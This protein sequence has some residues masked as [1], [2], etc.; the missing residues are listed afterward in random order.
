M[1]QQ[2]KNILKR[3]PPFKQFYQKIVSVEGALLKE[4][5]CL[6]NENAFIK[7]ALEQQN[8][9]VS[10]L[11]IQIKKLTAQLND[12]IPSQSAYLRDQIDNIEANL[13][14]LNT[15][16]NEELTSKLSG[17]SE[18]LLALEVDMKKK[19]SYINIDERYRY[20]NSRIDATYKQ[21]D[22]LYYKGLH[23]DFY[24]MAIAEWFQQ[25]TGDKLD[26][27]NP[28]T[29]NEKLQ[30]LK[31]YDCTSLKTLLVDKYL[32]RDWVSEKIG[33]EY[34]I[35]LLGVWNSYDEINFDS[36]PQKFVLKTN[37][38]SSWNLIV[39]NK[40][41]I[42]QKQA[43]MNFDKWMNTNFAFYNGF[44]LQ[45]LNV[46]RKIIAEEYLED[47]EKVS[48]YRFMCFNGEVKMVWLDT[49]QTDH[50]CLTFFTPEWKKMNI[51]M[52]HPIAEYDIPRPKNYEKMLAIAS[53]LSQGFAHVRVDLY[54]VDGKIYFGELTF[55]STSGTLG[56]EPKEFEYEMGDWI[57]LP[58]KQSTPRTIFGLAK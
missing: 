29:Y 3:I 19:Y 39:K 57:E 46:P 36:L 6:E 35:P 17:F 7:R 21:M 58:Q 40:N 14:E 33:S 44:E 43:K 23:P 12:A 18:S 55:S 48:D 9:L 5:N 32:V 53:T 13:N 10:E 38:G 31:L 24:E 28:K 11:D 45:Y 41:E 49:Y 4:I 50:R 2:L 8:N 42:N 25:K 56:I 47:L 16:Y 22:Y 51:K 1:K 30:W 34:L 27:E 37:H 26:L 54:N 52:R 20:L 15:F